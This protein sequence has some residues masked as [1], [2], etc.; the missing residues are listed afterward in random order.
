[1]RNTFV[2]EETV[3]YQFLS[4]STTVLRNEA[5]NIHAEEKRWNERFTFLDDLTE[6]QVDGLSTWDSY[7]VESIPF[8]AHGY[9]IFIED[10]LLADA[11]SQ[12]SQKQRDIILLSFLLD[13]K[14]VEIAKLMGIA[15]ST[16][17]YHKTK[18]FDE[19]RGFY[20]RRE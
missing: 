20:V 10:A 9:T 4:F 5:R 18:A 3:E 14:D 11:V 1:M 6:G 7:E 17:H 13:M 16:L 8:Y 2:D 15:N 19:L 12:L